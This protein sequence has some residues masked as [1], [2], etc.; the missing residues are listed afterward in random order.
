MQDVPRFAQQSHEVWQEAEGGMAVAGRPWCSAPCGFRVKYGLLS[1]ACLVQ[2]NQGSVS[3]LEQCALMG[4]LPATSGSLA[5][6]WDV[7]SFSSRPFGTLARGSASA[8]AG[9]KRDQ[10]AS[11][12]RISNKTISSTREELEE[13]QMHP[14]TAFSMPS[15]H[16]VPWHVILVQWRHTVHAV[17]DLTVWCTDPFWYILSDMDVS[18]L[19]VLDQE[20]LCQTNSLEDDPWGIGDGRYVHEHDLSGAFCDCLRFKST[21]C[22]AAGVLTHWELAFT[23]H[24]ASKFHVGR[25]LLWV[26]SNMR[27]PSWGHM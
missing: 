23:I 1:F 10:N 24:S 9:S 3:F 13:P 20:I 6:A 14:L 22:A 15:M 26:F 21:F 16:V 12:Q 19:N 5:M 18:Y 8:S 4:W 7:H 2:G 11:T 27:L 17:N 25:E